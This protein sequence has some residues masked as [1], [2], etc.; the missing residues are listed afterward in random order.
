MERVTAM[1]VEQF[2]AFL[3]LEC[4]LIEGVSLSIF[5]ASKWNRSRGRTLAAG[6]QESATILLLLG[7]F[8]SPADDPAV[9]KRRVVGA[10]VKL[11]SFFWRCLPALL[12]L[13]L[14]M[15]QPVVW[16]DSACPASGEKG[17]GV[18]AAGDS[19]PAHCAF[20]VSVP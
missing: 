11:T 8:R 20:H 7:A 12:S 17:V 6:G 13:E 19:A 3:P 4:F 1:P 18:P 9:L 10:A 16:P 5:L 2:A 14:L 15:A